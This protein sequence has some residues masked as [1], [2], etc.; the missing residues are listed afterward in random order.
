[1]H[2]TWQNFCCAFFPALLASIVDR[3]GL[4]YGTINVNTVI[5]SCIISELPGLGIKKGISELARGRIL[6]GK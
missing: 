3:F 5:I 1:L 6:A 2:N 4:L